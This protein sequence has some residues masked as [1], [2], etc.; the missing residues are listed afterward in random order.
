MPAVNVG[1]DVVASVGHKLGDNGSFLL[2]DQ[3]ADVRF[4]VLN[5]VNQDGVRQKKPKSLQQRMI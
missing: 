1:E 5:L 3:L 2:A 4:A